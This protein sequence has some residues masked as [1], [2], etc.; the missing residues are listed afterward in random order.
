MIFQGNDNDNEN[1]DANEGVDD[2]LEVDANLE[3]DDK[4]DVDQTT[5]C[6]LGW[7]LCLLLGPGIR[8]NVR[9]A[10]TYHHDQHHHR[11]DDEDEE[12]HDDEN[13]GDL[14]VLPGPEEQVGDDNE[15]LVELVNCVGDR[16]VQVIFL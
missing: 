13:H 2:K 8:R 14:V 10:A 9:V 5:L 4:E 11:C 6:L 12:E 7:M 1:F 3:V 15:I 16:P